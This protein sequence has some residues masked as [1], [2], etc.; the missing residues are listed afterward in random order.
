MQKQSKQ[1]S[2]GIMIPDLFVAQSHSY[3]VPIFF[4]GQSE[5]IPGDFSSKKS[6]RGLYFQ[7][8][9]R[10]SAAQSGFIV[11]KE[12]RHPIKHKNDFTSTGERL[13]YE[14]KRKISYS[15][16]MIKLD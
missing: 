14:N 13:C 7:A 8:R 6:R 3:E 16:L 12:N 4:F 5:K 11:S 15:S 9:K 2:N 1:L 10:T